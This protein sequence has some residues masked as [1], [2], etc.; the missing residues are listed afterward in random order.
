MLSRTRHQHRIASPPL[1]VGAF[2][3]LLSQSCAHTD[4]ALLTMIA[5]R[6]LVMCLMAVRS[7]AAFSLGYRNMAR[8]CNTRLYSADKAPRHD[9]RSEG[10]MAEMDPEEA[11]IQAA[12]AEHQ[13]HAPKLGWAT[14][15]RTLVAYN[16]GFAVMST[17]SKS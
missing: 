6:S 16:H 8:R 9:V 13:Q 4:T 2:I 3:V 1:L 17:N 10:A 5:T 7:V 14:D 15:I 12:F 11:K